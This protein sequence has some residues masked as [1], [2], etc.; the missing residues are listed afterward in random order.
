MHNPGK[1]SRPASIGHLLAS[2]LDLLLALSF[3]AF[4][5]KFG[6]D[7]TSHVSWPYDFDHFRDMAFTQT[8]AQGAWLSDPYYRGEFLWYNPLVPAIAAV[9]ERFADV[10]VHVLYARLGAYLN[11]LAPIT[12]FLLLRATVGP[13]QALAA[14]VVFLFATPRGAQGWNTA[15]YSPWLFPITFAQGLFYASLWSLHRLWQEPGTQRRMVAGVLVGLTFLAHTAPAL[16]L[17]GILLLRSAWTL[18]TSRR[19]PSPLSRRAVATDLAVVLGSAAILSLPFTGVIVGHYGLRIVNDAPRTWVYELL[20]I[21]NFRGL[22]YTHATVATLFALIGLVAWW[23]Q[24]ILSSN[25]AV[26]TWWAGVNLLLFLRGYAAQISPMV[27]RL[28]PG[29]VPEFHYL[30]YLRA[31]LAVSAGLGFVAVLTTTVRYVATRSGRFT[32]SA[33]SGFVTG[34][35]YAL[36]VLVAVLLGARLDKRFD[37]GSAVQEAR[38]REATL[39][40]RLYD[41]IRQNTAVDAVFL[42]TDDVTQFVIGPTGRK[43]VVVGAAF[44]NPYVEYVQRARDRDEMYAALLRSDQQTFCTRAQ[45]YQVAYVTLDVRRANQV[46]AAQQHAIMRAWTGDGI[47][48]WKVVGCP[49]S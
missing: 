46:S 4:A 18:Y 29:L 32:A 1:T 17:V 11:L 48:V 43:V 45:Q 3:I 12:F 21:Q 10:S 13:L 19:D 34:S 33:A 37:F 2:H 6:I 41:W 44:S 39:Q 24:G 31:L 7:A 8:M 26:F 38:Q 49:A 9:I 42:S 28:V 47:E 14:L 40:L 25:L 35:C 23:R 5:G 27:N 15:T 20:L 30:F 22:L 16:M 36:I